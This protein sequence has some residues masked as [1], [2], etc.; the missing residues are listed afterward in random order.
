MKKKKPFKLGLVAALATAAIAS[1]VVA[2]NATTPTVPGIS[3]ASSVFNSPDPAASYAA[4]SASE[5]NE[6][7]EAESPAA[8]TLLSQ[9]TAGLP[10]GTTPSAALAAAFTGTF[11]V[12][13]QW[14]EQAIAGNTLYTWWQATEVTVSAGTVTKV[15][16]YNYGYETDTPGWSKNTITTS[17]YNAGWEGRGVVDAQFVLGVGGW[18]IQHTDNCGQIRVNA[19]GNH[20]STSTSCDLN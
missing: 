17:K 1:P 19:D 8:T 9:S 3:I 20:Y 14:G 18:D 15:R 7:N 16:V 6:F 5:Q 12:S 11:S 13:S 10:A 2:A 4:L